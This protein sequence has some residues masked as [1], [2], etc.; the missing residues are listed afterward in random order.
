MSDAVD[1][2]T[3]GAGFI[4]SHLAETLLARGRRVRV[5]D[6]F[7]T[8]RRSILPRGVD[9]VE[10]DVNEVAGAAF[11]GASVVY[12]LAAL[13]SVPRS[14]K[15]PLESHQA[16]ARGTLTALAAAEQTGVKRLVFASSSSVYGDTPTL[17]KHER[18]PPRPLSPYAAAKLAGE[19]YAASWASR[20]VL[21][22][23]SLRFFNVY[24]P[25][26]DPDSPYAAVIPL[27]SR[28]LR[29]GKRMTV[30]GDG[31]QTRDFTFVTDVVEGLIRAGTSPGV[32]G[33]VYNLAGGRPVSV[34]DMG[35]TLARLSDKAADFEF[36]PPRPG[37]IRDSFADVD[38]ARRDLGFSAAV[39]LEEGLRRTLGWAAS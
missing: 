29:E 1:V 23:V 36:L 28:K 30:Y 20:G 25:R 16:T 13:P 26:Q 37:D 3:G 21:E 27:F 17:P 35:K 14:V 7:A 32:S 18:M 33:R 22:T 10:G 4:G 2:V 19:L 12:H 38:A 15:H 39:P 11:R 31:G 34:L 6:N 8:G 24:G 5:V 9:L